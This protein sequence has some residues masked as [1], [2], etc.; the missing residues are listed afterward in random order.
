[1]AIQGVK[2]KTHLDV[3]SGLKT[4]T[5]CGR[6]LHGWNLKRPKSVT[7]DPKLVTCEPC[8]RKM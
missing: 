6:S 3:S 8:L 4:E 5:A 2:V 7:D 1:M